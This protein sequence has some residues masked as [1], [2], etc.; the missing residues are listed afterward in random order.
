[1][2]LKVGKLHILI[3]LLLPP[4]DTTSYSRLAIGNTDLFLV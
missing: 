2:R 3:L 1:M 4:C